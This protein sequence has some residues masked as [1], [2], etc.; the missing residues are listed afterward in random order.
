NGELKAA[1]N[2]ALRE[3]R[4]SR[5]IE[6]VKGYLGEVNSFGDFVELSEKVQEFIQLELGDSKAS[7]ER[8]PKSWSSSLNSIAIPRNISLQ[9]ASHL[10]V[11]HIEKQWIL[12][13]LEQT[14]WK[15]GEAARILGIDSKTLYRKMRAYGLEGN[16]VG[17]T[18]PEEKPASTAG[19]A[20]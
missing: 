5:E 2:K 8:L 1:I 15:R 19:S 12:N 14:H 10:A 6:K 17:V 11:H 13:T 7:E 16:T 20:R 18:V 4:V 9:E 3:D